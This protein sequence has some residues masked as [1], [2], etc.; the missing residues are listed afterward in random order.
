MAW[1]SWRRD[2][3]TCQATTF[4]FVVGTIR[5]EGEGSEPGIAQRGAKFIASSIRFQF[6]FQKLSHLHATSSSF[7]LFESSCMSNAPRMQTTERC[8]WQISQPP[9]FANHLQRLPNHE[10]DE[11]CGRIGECLALARCEWIRARHQGIRVDL[12]VR[13]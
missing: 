9:E 3:R 12:A 1:S 7:V 8:E 6:K 13:G 11:V 4:R 5:F 10:G 2:Q